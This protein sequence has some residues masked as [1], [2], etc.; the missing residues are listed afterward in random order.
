MADPKFKVGDRVCGIDES[1]L[2]YID[3][4][5]FGLVSKVELDQEGNYGGDFRYDLTF[6][7]GRI[8]TALY[9]DEIASEADV[10]AKKQAHQTIQAQA[11]PLVDNACALLQQAAKI[12]KDQGIQLSEMKDLI[13]PL[14]DAI[15]AVGWSSSSLQC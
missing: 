6:D 7:G 3:D 10:V 11:K 2:A 12:A 8:E 5:E 14:Y 15:D 4:I 1:D 9:E 13:D